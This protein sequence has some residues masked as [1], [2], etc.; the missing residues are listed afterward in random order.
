ML[1]PKWRDPKTFPIDSKFTQK[2]A[3]AFP[4]FARLRKNKTVLVIFD[5]DAYQIVPFRDAGIIMGAL[6]T[7]LRRSILSG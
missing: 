4:D 1:R 5:S 7:A 2:R 6:V 3:T